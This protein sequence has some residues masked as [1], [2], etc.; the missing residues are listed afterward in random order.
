MA[1]IHGSS[2][3]SNV[4]SKVSLKWGTFSMYGQVEHFTL[5]MS[6]YD[7]ILFFP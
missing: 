2:A 5:R 4:E 6:S 3:I 1:P 7:H